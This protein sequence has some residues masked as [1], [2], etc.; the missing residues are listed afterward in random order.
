MADTY[1][2]NFWA[3]IMWRPVKKIQ[4]IIII[5]TNDSNQHGSNY[6]KEL[7]NLGRVGGGE[8]PWDLHS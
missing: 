4:E 1:S 5:T 6:S 8:Q 2:N 3:S 7:N